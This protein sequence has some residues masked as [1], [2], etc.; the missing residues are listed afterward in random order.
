MLMPTAL[1]LF[2]QKF[3]TV[4]ILSLLSCLIGL[5]LTGLK[6][7]DPDNSSQT[8]YDSLIDSGSTP[9][10]PIMILELVEGYLR[11]LSR[12]GSGRIEILRNCALA[13]H[14][15]HSSDDLIVPAW[16]N[17]KRSQS[18]KFEQDWNLT[19]WT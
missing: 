4:L 1:N 5:L 18:C 19:K 7:Q 6:V 16:R 3:L 10:H 13:L 12:G 17:V 11:Y 9:T 14:L 8:V 15:L 2:L